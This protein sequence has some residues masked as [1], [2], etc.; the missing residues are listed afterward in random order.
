M[1]NNP[2]KLS[3]SKKRF[4]SGI[5]VIVVILS[6]LVVSINS[7]MVASGSPSILNNKQ[8]IHLDNSN[9]VT[10][11]SNAG[12]VKYT[13]DLLNNTLMN[14]NIVNIYNGLYPNG[15]AYDPANNYVYVT[16]GGSNSVSVINGATNTVVNSITVGS[17]PY[18]VAYDPANNYVYVTNDGS[19]SVAIL[20]SLLIFF[21]SFSPISF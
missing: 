18:G 3:T 13:L 21:T 14:G 1:N 15:V 9:P 20:S 19:N 2:M 7:S 10:K 17:E 6:L 8:A 4:L 5:L 11:T 16:N 12:Y